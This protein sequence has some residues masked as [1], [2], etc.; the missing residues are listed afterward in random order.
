[1]TAYIITI[2]QNLLSKTYND[3]NNSD[4]N[5]TND[6]D[7]TVSDNFYEVTIQIYVF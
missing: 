4:E 6:N 5:D 1:M 2:V 7:N 3:E